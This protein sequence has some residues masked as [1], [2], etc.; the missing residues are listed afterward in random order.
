MHP[1]RPNHRPHPRPRRREEA[2]PR[3]ERGGAFRRERAIDGDGDA[4][5]LAHARRSCSPRSHRRRR[6]RGQQN[7]RA[8]RRVATRGD[9]HAPQDFTQKHRQARRERRREG[10]GNR[11][12]PRGTEADEFSR[13]RRSDDERDVRRGIRGASLARGDGWRGRAFRGGAERVRGGCGGGWESNVGDC[14]FAL[15]SRGDSRVSFRGRRGGGGDEIRAKGALARAR[16]ANAGSGGGGA[17]RIVRRDTAIGERRARALGMARRDRDRPLLVDVGSCWDFFRRFDASFRVV[18]LD[19]CPRRDEVLTCDFLGMRIGAP[20]EAIVT[21]P[22]DPGGMGARRLES[23]PPAP[24]TPPSCPS[25]CRTC[26]RRD[27]A[28]R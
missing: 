1:A 9:H 19:L 11:S 3:A 27:N 6:R 4:R 18:A 24:P 28:A 17:P 23:L 25:S 14:G 5:Q 13:L 10:C 15:V 21:A 16:R 26:P 2:S 22:V 20:D 7:P 12:K 8:T